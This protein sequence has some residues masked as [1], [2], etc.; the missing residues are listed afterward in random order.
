[1]HVLASRYVPSQ[2]TAYCMADGTLF[3][4]CDKPN[5]AAAA[6][7]AEALACPMAIDPRL[8]H[9]LA[10]DSGFWGGGH[11]GARQGVQ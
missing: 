5:Y 3:L 7:A 4:K 6:A 11:R 10:L 8:V 1:M 2:M 9:D